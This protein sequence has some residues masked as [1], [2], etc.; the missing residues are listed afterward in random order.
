MNQ[1]TGGLTK[2]GA[3]T[4][5]L[6][7]TNAYTGATT[8]NNGGGIL[9]IEAAAALPAASAIVLTRAGL[10]TGSMHFNLS[11]TQVINHPFTFSSA[12]SFANGG[13][14]TI[15]SLQGNLTLGGNM[16]I[17]NGGGN[18]A[19][20][21]S[22]A[23]LLTLSGTLANTVSAA[24]RPFSLG[25]AGNGV[26]SGPVNNGAGGQ[27]TSITKNGAGTWSL[28]GA[29]N[30][31]TGGVHLLE[32]ILDVASL[33]N[34]GVNSSIGAG[35][36]INF[37]GQGSSG[38]LQY[39]G[40]TNQ[41][42]NR[43]V[44]IAATGGTLDS[45][46]AGAMAFTGAFS[47]TNVFLN[48]VFANGSDVITNGASIS[49]GVV[50]GMTLPSSV[51]GLP[52]GT[53]ITAINGNKYTLSN[54]FTGTGA[55]I[56]IT[57]EGAPERVLRL[58]GSNVGN[59]EISGSLSDAGS[60]GKL[61]L[62]KAGP[63]HWALTGAN[64]YTGATAVE[65]GTLLVHGSITGSAVTVNN[66]GTLGGGSNPVSGVITGSVTVNAGGT[67]APGPGLGTLQTGDLSFGSGATFALEI[68]SGAARS[69]LAAI[70]GNFSLA[71][72]DNV[73]LT[74]SDLAAAPFT[75][76]ALTFITYSG[77]WD[78]DLFT[79]GGSIIPDGGFLTV[80][81]NA[82]QLDYNFGNNSVALI[83]V[84]EPASLL[85]GIGLLFGLR[86]RRRSA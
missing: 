32:G 53:T 60:V 18:G 62:T 21:Q 34:T 20:I 82:F 51:A 10:G 19:I 24:P 54:T 76:G 71:D 1:T 13:A 36:E 73:V 4:L 6:A 74:I 8:V 69:D 7:G 26:V 64:T 81:T 37:T 56:P 49:P 86:R 35:G 33:S 68:A 15:R 25:G 47:S 22:D 11:G 43:P 67:L 38:T 58:T 57:F 78:G 28:T 27:Q 44:N 40:A 72:A 39:T 42:T 61:G 12:N 14:A 3:G 41:T 31:F 75:S 46:G 55:G 30:N 5:V 66:T 9:R 45:S 2:S 48:L 70:T 80:G 59:N 79:Y 50:V 65:A 85:A 29:N 16:T 52:A 84:P 63:G 83:A 17:T 77:A 23:G